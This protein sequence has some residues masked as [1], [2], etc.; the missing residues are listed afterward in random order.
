[1]AVLRSVSHAWRINI[2]LAI[3]AAL[4]DSGYDETIGLYEDEAEALSAA[5]GAAETKRSTL[6]GQALLP[7]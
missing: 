1:M 6:G 2:T 5:Q 7:E 3:E 4:N